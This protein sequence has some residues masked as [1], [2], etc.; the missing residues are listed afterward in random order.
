MLTSVSQQTLPPANHIVLRDDGRGF[1][2]TVN[3]AV[4]LVDTEY[5]CLV[6]DDDLLLPHHVEAL[7]RALPE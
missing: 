6:D 5:F 4:S 7:T 3:R 2:E 1:V